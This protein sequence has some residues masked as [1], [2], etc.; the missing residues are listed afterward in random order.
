M[1]ETAMIDE[2]VKLIAHNE[3]MRRQRIAA[4][5]RAAP[6][7]L[8]ALKSAMGA[9]AKRFSEEFPGEQIVIAGDG[10]V[11]V[12]CPT[13]KL[14]SRATV[15]LHPSASQISCVFENVDLQNWEDLLEIDDRDGTLHSMGM[16]QV[17][18]V[19]RFSRKILIPVM[20][21]ILARQPTANSFMK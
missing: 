5:E 14:A 13:Y 9:H 17:Q 20:F 12:V 2:W 1:G 16:A 3:R 4:F 19:E 11:D 18:T 6:A 10:F 21:P 15:R 8:E 7:F